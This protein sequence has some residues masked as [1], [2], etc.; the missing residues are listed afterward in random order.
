ML[1]LIAYNLI[2]QNSSRLAQQ[3]YPNNRTHHQSLAHK[4][5]A[6]AFPAN[7]NFKAAVIE[8]AKLVDRYGVHPVEMIGVAVS[9]AEPVFLQTARQTDAL[10]TPHKCGRACACD[11]AQGS[12]LHLVMLASATAFSSSHQ[13]RI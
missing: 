2:G 5:K 11:R 3:K 12:G 13:N 4:R 9:A 1:N 10:P 8:V 7:F 6:N